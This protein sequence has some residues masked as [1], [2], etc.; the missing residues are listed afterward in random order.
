M[1]VRLLLS[2]SWLEVL[3]M[4]ATYGRMG[5]LSCRPT[6]RIHGHRASRLL[7][8]TVLG[9]TDAEPEQA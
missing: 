2:S 4:S 3:R 6:T 5:C 7:D 8:D 1:R 9:M